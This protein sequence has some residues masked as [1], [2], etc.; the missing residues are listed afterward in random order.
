MT[1][2]R[3]LHA[4]DLHLGS[5]FQ[6]LTLKDPDIAERFSLASRRAFSNL[7]Q[8]AIELGVEFVVIAGDVYDGEWRDNTIGL[9]FNREV[10]RLANAGIEVYLLRGNH[11]AASVVTKSIRL[12]ASVHEFD[13]RRP[14]TFHIERL[15]VALHG[16]GFAERSAAE[17]LAIAYPAPVSGA[18]N[19]GVLHTSLTGRPPHA[20]YAPCSLED[21]VARGYDYWALGHVH[22]YE[23]VNTDPH[24]VF[25][26][27]LQGRNVRETGDKGAVLVSVEDGRVVAT[28]RV[29]V[30]EARWAALH[31]DVDGLADLDAVLQAVDDSVHDAVHAAENRLLAVR[32]RLV[33]R[34]PLRSQLL[35]DRAAIRDEIQAVC[36]RVSSDTWL[37]KLDLAITAPEQHGTSIDGAGLRGVLPEIHDV[38]ALEEG[39][40]ALLAE[41]GARI[42][43]AGPDWLPPEGVAD[44]VDDARELL[45]YRAGQGS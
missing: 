30:D 33:G 45:L 13:T 31:V 7:V 11:D 44:L 1:S 19:I 24:V 39:A 35:A 34:S 32:I 12:P 20:N 22:D 41:V 5:P 43:A 3:F 36:H 10:A 18:F 9:F 8:R 37:E 42:R 29:I 16:Q 27:N 25:P 40:R 23:M 14:Q 15:G 28:E 6:G 38:S 17:N 4:A 21:L 26:G 2:F